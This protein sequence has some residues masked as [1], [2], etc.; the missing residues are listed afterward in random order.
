MTLAGVSPAE[1]P[2][3]NV[4]GGSDGMLSSS[5]SASNCTT[6][7]PG[8]VLTRAS[9]FGVTSKVTATL[10]VPASTRATTRGTRRSPT[11]S[12]RAARRRSSRT[13]SA[14]DSARGMKSTG[15]NQRLS[16]RTAGAGSETSRPLTDT[17]F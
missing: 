15:T 11:T 13:S 17:T 6:T 9:V 5:A 8:W 14:S 16:R 4:C 3:R 1:M 12:R 7:R 10:V 2:V